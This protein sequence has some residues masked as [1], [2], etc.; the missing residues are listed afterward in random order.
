[1]INQV[2]ILHSYQ[3]S[4]SSAFSMINATTQEITEE[5]GIEINLPRKAV[6]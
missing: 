6:R 4:L 5:L 3:N 1:M 2:D